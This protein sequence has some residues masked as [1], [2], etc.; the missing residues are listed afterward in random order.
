MLSELI[1][2]LNQAGLDLEP[3]E[4]EAYSLR[5]V[6]ELRSDLAEDAGLV[7]EESV[8]DGAMSGAAALVLGVLKAEV[9]IA[10]VGKVLKW[11]WTL[12]PN[13]VQKITYKKDGREVVLEYQN[14]AQLEEQI[15]ALKTIDTFMIQLIQTK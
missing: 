4:L 10:N 9:S 11:L 12:K 14:S 13:A 15:E 3:D 8:P 6:E 2:D 5:L 7:R 1:I